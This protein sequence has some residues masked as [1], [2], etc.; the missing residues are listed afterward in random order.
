MRGHQQ[1]TKS[2]IKSTIRKSKGSV[3]SCPRVLHGS[4]SCFPGF[5]LILD[6]TGRREAWEERLGVLVRNL[7]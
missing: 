5:S 2:L 1:S 3:V 4:F 6:T 7:S